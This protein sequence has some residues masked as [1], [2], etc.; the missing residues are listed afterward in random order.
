M[1]EDIKFRVWDRVFNNYWTDEGIKENASWLLFPNN[2]NIHDIK[3]EKCTGKKDKN[4]KLIY[5]GDLF[6]PI[7]DED[8][9]G[10]IVEV[11]WHQETSGF[12][13]CR[14]GRFEDW[15]GLYYEWRKYE[16]IEDLE[17]WLEQPIIGN[18]NEN[19]ELLE[20]QK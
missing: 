15:N 4:G 13:V 3:I 19:P 6:E 17:E 12:K 11:I 7:Y 10:E 9:P 8:F 2:E 20:K 5:E 16:E 18:I 14:K 1:N